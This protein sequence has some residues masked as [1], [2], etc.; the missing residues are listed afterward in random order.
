MVMD[1]FEKQ[2]YMKHYYRMWLKPYRRMMRR[3]D[4]IDWAFVAITRVIKAMKKYGYSDE[5]IKRLTAK[6]KELSGRKRDELDPMRL[7]TAEEVSERFQLK[8]RQVKELAR[9]GKIPS[10][11]VGRLRRFPE[12]SLRDWMK[13]GV[14][15]K[16]SESEIDSIVDQIIS[17]VS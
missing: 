2:F 6:H 16:N 10:I 15:P 8:V 11:K 7:L 17:E 13:N 3:K 5:E 12:D 14:V 1:K 4:P 9:Q